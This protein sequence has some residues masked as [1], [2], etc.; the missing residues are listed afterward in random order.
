M[1]QNRWQPAD[2][3]PI[4]ELLLWKSTVKLVFFLVVLEAESDD[5]GL[6]LSGS[7]FTQ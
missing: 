6:V 4:I 5:C 1:F 2:E 7:L 3:A